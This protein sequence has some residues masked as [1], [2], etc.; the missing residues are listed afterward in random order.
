MNRPSEQAMSQAAPKR[1]RPATVTGG[2]HHPF[3]DGLVTVS[4][5][6]D[7]SKSLTASVRG[8]HVAPHLT[9]YDAERVWALADQIRMIVYRAQWRATHP[10]ESDP[11]ADC[12]HRNSES[13]KCLL[14]E[15][16]V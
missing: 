8:A 11:H 16:N 6:W 3:E 7:G 9:D 12:P 2:H 4:M 13:D 15:P 14:E 1:H 5:G 10:Q